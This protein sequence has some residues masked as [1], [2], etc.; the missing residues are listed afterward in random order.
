MTDP[1]F[2]HP[3]CQKCYQDTMSRHGKFII[4]CKGIKES[5][6]LITPELAL[7]LSPEEK[8]L[9]LQLYDSVT[10]A[11]DVL[12]WTPRV[13]KDGIEYQSMMLK[14]TAKR[15]VFRLGRRTGKTASIAIRALHFLATQKNGKVLVVTP[16]KAQIDIIF[17]MVK[18]HIGKSVDLQNSIKRQVSTPFHEIQLWNGSYI[19]GFT[20]GSKSGGEAGSIRGQAADILILDE[21]DYLTD[22]DINS[23]VAILQDHPN[24]QLWA[25]STPTGRRAKFF[26][27]CH[28]PRYKEFHFPSH[29]LPHYNDEID[30]EHRENLT[31]AAYLHEILAE[32]GEEEEGVLQK[33][34]IDRARVDYS[35][36]TMKPTAGWIYGIGV[37]WNAARIGTEIVVVGWNGEKLM[38]VEAVNISIVGWTQLSAIEQLVALNDKWMPEFIYV[39]EGFGSTQIEVLKQYGLENIGKDPNKARLKDIIKPINFSSTIE[40]YDPFDKQPV[41]KPMKPFIVENAV[42]YFEQE[43]V[44]IS[45]DDKILVDQLENYII[46]RRTQSGMPVYCAREERIGDH[47]L[48]AFF[49]ALLGFAQNYSSLLKVSY[50]VSIA[51]TRRIGEAQIQQQQLAEMGDAIVVADPRQHRPQALRQHRQAPSDRMA[52]SQDIITRGAQLP[53]HLIGDNAPLWAH[54]GFMRDEP[55]P[56]SRGRLLRRPMRKNI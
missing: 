55:P 27:Y 14:C 12:N 10:W 25:S 29:V 37:D 34:Y 22:G 9:A 13:S 16:Y 18:E 46:Q 6:E 52:I 47:R 50:A 26:E 56:S 19:R 1:R 4:S 43:T 2:K 32:F 30:A 51:I 33:Q 3:Y 38:P 40:V 42:R 31:Q 49:L 41:K 48:D 15:K 45:R 54:P 24:T 20:S 8:R 28:S 17:D 11:S 39:D 23:I 35:Y 53:G 44:S 7:M 36:E 5:D 21:M